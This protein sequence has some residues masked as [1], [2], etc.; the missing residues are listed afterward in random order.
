MSKLTHDEAAKKL[1]AAGIT[2]SSS[3]NCSIRSSPKCTSFDQI[4]SATIEGIIALKNESNCA[5]NITGGTEVGHAGGTRSHGTGYK[6]D[7]TPSEDISK[8]ITTNFKYIGEREGDKAKM[9]KAHKGTIYARES[10]HWD[11]TFI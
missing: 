1:E 11:I 2:W 7:I 5:I 10:N 8:Y 9:Y 3:G 6:L 4:N